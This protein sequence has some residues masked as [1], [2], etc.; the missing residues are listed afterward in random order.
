MRSSDSIANLAAALVTAQG[1][2]KAVHKDREN[3]HFRNK[4]ATLDAIIDAVRPALAKHGLAVVSGATRPLCSDAGT[5]LGF[6]VSSTLLH[7]SGEWLESAAIMP[8][9]KHDPQGAGSAM[10]YGRRYSLSA[11][12]SLATDDDD[13]G[14]S[15][16]PPRQ[17]TP[18]RPAA[19]A[20]RPAAPRA[21]SPGPQRLGETMQA[22]VEALDLEHMPNCPKCAGAMWDN[23]AGKKNPK[24]PDWKCKDKQ[25]DGVVWPPKQGTAAPAARRAVPKEQ[26]W[27]DFPPELEQE[28]D[29]LPF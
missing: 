22:A 23:R 13:D 9:A 15:A 25:C 28:P 1:E 16:M 26:S 4:Y 6:E 21:P 7:S 27:E 3:S 11:L 10:T 29:E 19:P 8:L 18:A 14:E 2:L 24:A 20:P 5:L 12:L 17:A